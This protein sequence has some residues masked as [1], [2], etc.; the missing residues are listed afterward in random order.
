M[1]YAVLHPNEVRTAISLDNRRMPLPR[2]ASPRIVSLRADDVPA[3]P[4]VIPSEEEQRAFG[5]QV[6]PMAGFK[7]T[8]LNDRATLEQRDVLVRVLLQ[9][10]L[11][12]VDR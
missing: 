9:A 2:T 3:D 4:G 12:G 11:G 7:H 1:L 8:D 6:I 10:L 5:V